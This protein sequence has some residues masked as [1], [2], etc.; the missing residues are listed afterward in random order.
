MKIRRISDSK[1][2]DG[3]KEYSITKC[4]EN[5]TGGIGETPGAI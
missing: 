1:P 5:G 2:F 3:M 4:I